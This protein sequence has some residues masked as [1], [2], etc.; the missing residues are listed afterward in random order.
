MELHSYYSYPA[1]PTVQKAFWHIQDNTDLKANA[2]YGSR[3]TY[4]GN[5]SKHTLSIRNL[6]PG[7]SKD[8]AF[9]FITK[10]EGGWSGVY[11]PLTVTGKEDD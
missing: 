11:V 5:S 4:T 2:R 1:N 9:R 6:N 7:D 3:V 8:Y 10:E